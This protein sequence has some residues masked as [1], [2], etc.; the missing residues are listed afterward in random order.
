MSCSWATWGVSSNHHNERN[1]N[2]YS[3]LYSRAA[4]RTREPT[5]PAFAATCKCHHRHLLRDDTLF[6]CSWR[7]VWY[8]VR[9][10]IC[11]I[12][13][14]IACGVRGE[15]RFGAFCLNQSVIFLKCAF[16]RVRTIVYR[17]YFAR[18]IPHRTLPSVRHGHNTLQS[19][20]GKVRYEVDTRTQTIRY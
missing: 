9:Q 5:A 14:A 3:Y 10:K 15:T 7:S 1:E 20:P 17:G 19:S 4:R 16:G 18:W 11:E 13:V 12:W 8:H 2:K 6:H